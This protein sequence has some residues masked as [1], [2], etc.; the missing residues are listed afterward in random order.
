MSNTRNPIK[1]FQVIRF[2]A[3]FID[4]TKYHWCMHHYSGRTRPISLEASF[5]FFFWS[6]IFTGQITVVSLLVLRWKTFCG[7]SHIHALLNA[8]AQL[9]WSPAEKFE[10]F[11]SFYR[12]TSYF[13]PCIFFVISNFVIQSSFYVEDAYYYKQAFEDLEHC[14]ML[15]DI[16]MPKDNCCYMFLNLRSFCVT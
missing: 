1:S 12:T 3:G 16:I 5:V 8:D 4:I 10:N 7:C 2:Y 15:L 9:C 13:S 11:N 14:S 6:Q